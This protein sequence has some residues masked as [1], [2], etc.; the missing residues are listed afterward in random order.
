MPRRL[1]PA[2]RVFV[3]RAMRITVAPNICVVMAKKDSVIE[4]WA[5]ATVPEKAVAAVEKELPP[6]WTATLTRRRLTTPRATR[7]KMRPD[8]VQKL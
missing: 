4:D 2:E 3:I 7:L 6:G 1:S 5:A 8:S